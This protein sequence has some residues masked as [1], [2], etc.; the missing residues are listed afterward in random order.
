MTSAGKCSITET[1]HAGAD[2][3]GASGQIAQALM[4]RIIE[5]RLDCVIDPVGHIPARIQ[6]ETAVHDLNT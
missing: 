1:A 2:I 6:V 5:V 4:E 3:R